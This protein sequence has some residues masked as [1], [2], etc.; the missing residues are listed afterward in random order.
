MKDVLNLS[1]DNILSHVV[2]E[3]LAAENA[4]TRKAMEEIVAERDRLSK[5]GKDDHC[6]QLEVLINGHKVNPE[7]FFNLYKDQWSSLVKRAAQELIHERLSNKFVDIIDK[8]QDIEQVVDSW[9]EE[10]NWEVPN[11][12]KTPKSE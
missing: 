5:E 1:S 11:P 12:F 6:I 10:V 4:E 9:I 7:K 8:I 2:L 3:C